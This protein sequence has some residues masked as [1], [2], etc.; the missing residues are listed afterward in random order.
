MKNMSNLENKRNEV[1]RKIKFNDPLK[2]QFFKKLAETSNPF[3]WLNNLIEEG[4]FDPRNFPSIIEDPEKEGYYTIPYWEPSGYLEN[5]AKMNS[6]DEDPE[7]TELLLSII[8]DYMFEKAIKRLIDDKQELLLLKLLNI[9]L[10]FKKESNKYY[11]E[12]VSILDEFWLNSTLKESKPFIA[13]FCPLNA[14]KVALNKIS[15]ILK[16]DKN[17]F[18][19]IP[20][21][22]DHP[23]TLFPEEDYEIQLVHF[24]RDMFEYLSS[25]SIFSE[26]IKD[27]AQKLINSDYDIFKRIGIYIINLYYDELN[28][29]FWDWDVNP[30]DNINLRHDIYRFFNLNYSKFENDTNKIELIIKW[31]DNKKYIIEL[32]NKKVEPSRIAY[33]KLRWLSAFKSSENQKIQS[34]ITKYQELYPNE[35][36]HPDFDSW[37]SK[38]SS[39]PLYYDEMLKMSN[40]ELAEYLSNKNIS[41]SPFE[42]SDLSESLIKLVSS[43][44]EQFSKDLYP[45]L[46]FSRKNQY[47]LIY[48]LLVAWR[49]EKTFNCEEL[50]E[51]FIEIIEDDDFWNEQTTDKNSIVSVIADFIEI[52]TKDDRYAIEPNLLPKIEKILLILAHNAKSDLREMHDLVNSVLNSTL[53]KIYSAMIIYSLKCVRESRSFPVAIK[54]TIDELMIK[55]T[56]ELSVTLGKYLPNLCALDKKWAKNS[57]QYI[58]PTEPEIWKPAFTG[59]LFYSATIYEEIYDILKETHNY[60]RAIK[61]EFDDRNITQKL[62]Q[63]IA[64]FYLLDKEDLNDPNSLISKLINNK[65]PEKV[66]QMSFLIHFISS[67]ES[68]Q[69]KKLWSRIY[70]EFSDIKEKECCE[71]IAKL[72]RW[73]E[74]IDKIDDDIFEWLISSAKCMESHSSMSI[75]ITSLA[76]H[77]EESPEEIGEI[78]LELLEKTPQHRKKDIIKIVDVLFQNKLYHIAN[79]ICNVYRRNGVDFLRDVHKKY[80]AI[81]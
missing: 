19:S 35:I 16:V 79:H 52:T 78:Y 36:E 39:N 57:F 24:V 48:G 51:F 67:R 32:E 49:S 37:I 44:P 12:Y 1:L 43:H 20:A 18:N 66:K 56:I 6:I 28:D 76:E 55:P 54:E 41:E 45:F 29:I 63:H 53:G 60:Q 50:L 21:I 77:V 10:N 15:D 59:Y 74:L 3:P 22:E 8:G 33:H 9:I 58:F 4:Y 46:Y 26:E 68:D 14:S 40:Q 17:Q 73:T 75:F 5:L 62:V 72:S 70:N 25:E 34:L 13:K 31:I 38:L 47:N 23:Q 80:N 71:I 30:L 64:T 11:D 27:C 65:N 61:T 7:T 81:N 42:I 69:V 2:K